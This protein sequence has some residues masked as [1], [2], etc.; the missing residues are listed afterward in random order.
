MA[1]GL[2]HMNQAAHLA[3]IFH[4]T[5]NR[6]SLKIQRRIQIEKDNIWFGQH[7]MRCCTQARRDSPKQPIMHLEPAASA[8]A[9]MRSAV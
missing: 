5:N 2:G 4:A 7:Q 9:L 3:V 8:T 1:N 6:I